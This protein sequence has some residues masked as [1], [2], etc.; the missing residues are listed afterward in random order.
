[1]LTSALATATAVNVGR[2]ANWLNGI[3]TALTRRSPLAAL[4]QVS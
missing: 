1:M 2:I 4:A 3:P